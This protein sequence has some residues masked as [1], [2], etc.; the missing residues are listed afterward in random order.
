MNVCNHGEHYETPCIKQTK[1]ALCRDSCDCLS[2]MSLLANYYTNYSVLFEVKMPL[3]VLFSLVTTC[4][5]TNI[6]FHCSVYKVHYW[7]W[8]Y[9]FSVKCRIISKCEVTCF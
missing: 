6:N 5:G 9:Y 4:F 8:L 7:L 3:V 2:F 1:N